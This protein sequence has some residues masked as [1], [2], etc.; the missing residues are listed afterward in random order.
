MGDLLTAEELGARLRVAP[1][2]ILGWARSG[3][4]P[5][6]RMSPKVVRFRLDEVVAALQRRTKR[7]GRND[8]CPA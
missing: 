1:G 7:K 6:V 2:T 3:H 5:A 4:I 8:L